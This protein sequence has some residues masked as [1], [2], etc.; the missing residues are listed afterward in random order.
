MDRLV[1]RVQGQTHTWTPGTGWIC[2]DFRMPSTRSCIIAP[3]GSVQMPMWKVA[4]LHA[5]SDPLLIMLRY[6]FLVWAV[7][8]CVCVC[9]RKRE[10]DRERDRAKNT[11]RKR[12]LRMCSRPPVAKRGK[13][14]KFSFV[15]IILACSYCAV[16]F[17]ATHQ[18]CGSTSTRISCFHQ[19]SGD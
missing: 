8:V 19:F 4:G 11:E 14:E 1:A 7:C 16:A 6:C 2:N 5:V 9:E 12:F 17:K 18:Y 3:H 10:T 13:N 15:I